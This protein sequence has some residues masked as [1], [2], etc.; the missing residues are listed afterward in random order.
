MPDAVAA[1]ITAALV[2]LAGCGPTAA[3]QLAPAPPT[4][5]M[6]VPATGPVTGQ[7]VTVLGVIRAGALP[8]CDT[9]LAEDGTH[10]LLLDTTDPPRDVPVEVIGIPDPSL[11]SYCNGG[12][13]LHV[14]RIRRRCR[15]GSSSAVIKLG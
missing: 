11:V 12:R 2:T 3:T 14:Q 15:R 8:G 6:T 10:Y 4:P 13:P 9:L 5:P 1:L 7:P